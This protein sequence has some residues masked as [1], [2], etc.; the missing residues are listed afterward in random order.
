VLEDIP[1]VTALVLRGCVDNCLKYA[2]RSG[3]VLDCAIVLIS[4]D[5]VKEYA[6]TV[7]LQTMAGLN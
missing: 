2:V 5:T 7:V 1:A 4:E 3:F 6:V